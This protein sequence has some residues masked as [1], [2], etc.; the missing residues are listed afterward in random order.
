[1]ELHVYSCESNYFSNN[2]RLV[3]KK[4]TNLNKL[5]LFANNFSQMHSQMNL[6][7]LPEFFLTINRTL[8]L[9]QNQNVS[10]LV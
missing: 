5:F 6:P 10:Y 1:M 2:C 7:V 8:I 3:F 4:K 9:F